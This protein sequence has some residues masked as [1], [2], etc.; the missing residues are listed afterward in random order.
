MN[1]TERVCN[2]ALQTTYSTFEED[3][4][5][6]AKRRL[7]DSFGCMAAGV[8]AVGNDAVYKTLKQINGPC[9]STVLFHSKKL[10]MSNASLMNSIM[11]RS[12]EYE[13]VEAE[14]KD[15]KMAQAHI[16]GSTISSALA[17]C[18][19]LG[20][21]GQM[22]LTGMLLGDDL[23]CRLACAGIRAPFESYW[24]VTGTFNVLGA[25]LGASYLLGL[26]EVQT[27][28]AIGLSLNTAGGTIGNY[29]D[30]AAAF[31][32]PIAL[33]ASNAVFAA[34]LAKNGFTAMDDPIGGAGG[35]FDLF[36]DS[37]DEE[38][39]FHG[40]GATHFADCVIKP[41]SSCRATHTAIE[42][43]LEIVH[44]ND[45]DIDRVSRI[46]LHLTPIVAD[47]FVG[48]EFDCGRTPQVKGFFNL[49]YATAVALMKGEVFPESFSIE[50]MKDPKLQNIISKI[51]LCSDLD[52]IEWGYVGARL[53][54]MTSQG[55][56]YTA[57]NTVA[58]GNVHSKPLADEM[59]Y[60]KY[61]RNVEFGGR[62]SLKQA[63]QALNL[64][65][66]I[67]SLPTLESLLSIFR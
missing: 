55:D 43:A 49:R 58:R 33:A 26:D 42:S 29:L 31:K 30:A 6:R 23:C 25:T 61:F 62:L 12:Y 2:A 1:V 67:E 22:F 28:D 34:Q 38:I 11:M 52:P 35:Y 24:D 17:I 66:V 16:A 36:C 56:T 60:E 4:I 53:E 51:E 32:F 9:E 5:A 65:M 8:Y 27:R 50:K 54:V 64:I 37:Y 48:G 18:E 41:Y 20:L 7:V 59:I 21:S 10:S 57:S 19:N 3:T 44:G 45:V 13:P 15:G 63:E 47:S 14:G 39:F 46:V 40:L